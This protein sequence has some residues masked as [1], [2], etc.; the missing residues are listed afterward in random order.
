[1]RWRIAIKSNRAA[2]LKSRDRERDKDKATKLKDKANRDRVKISRNR[3]AASSREAKANRAKESKK[4]TS[5]REKAETSVRQIFVKPVGFAS[6]PMGF[7]L[8]ASLQSS[9]LTKHSMTD[10]LIPYLQ[11][12]LG[13]ARFA[14]SLLRDLTAQEVDPETARVTADLLPHIEG[15]RTILEEFLASKRG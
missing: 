10:T 5:R 3:R 4:G 1:M 15:D 13:G 8:R 12:H 2:R 14:I 9:W 7:A 11:D 6:L